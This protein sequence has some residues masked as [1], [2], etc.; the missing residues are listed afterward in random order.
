MLLNSGGIHAKLN[1][2]TKGQYFNELIRL[3]GS[4]SFRRAHVLVSVSPDST[5]CMQK[6]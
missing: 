1:V 5:A 4:P 2:M 6:K 3:R